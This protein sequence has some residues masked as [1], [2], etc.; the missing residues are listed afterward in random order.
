MHFAPESTQTELC[1][2]LSP[3]VRVY[4]FLVIC[5]LFCC[6]FICRSDVVSFVCRSVVVLAAVVVVGGRFFVFAFSCSYSNLEIYIKKIHKSGVN[7]KKLSQAD[8]R[9]PSFSCWF[10]HV[11]VRACVCACVCVCMCV[12]AFS[13]T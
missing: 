13:C 3:H 9:M 6:C 10:V 7:V 1:I 8:V 4:L 5:L 2:V 11:C 12:P